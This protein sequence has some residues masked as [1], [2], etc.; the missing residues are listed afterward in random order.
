M[1][2]FCVVEIAAFFAYSVSLLWIEI[3]ENIKLR[4][5]ILNN[6]PYPIYS[7]Q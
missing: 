7:I 5:K 2:I 6:H 1:S 3:E 4:P